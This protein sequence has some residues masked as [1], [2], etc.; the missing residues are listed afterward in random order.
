M[1]DHHSLADFW[2]EPIHTYTRADALADGVLV[3]VTETAREAGFRIPVALTANVWADVNDLSGRYVSTGQSLDGRLWDLLFMAAHAARRPENRDTSEF[4]YALIMPVGTGNNY[5]AKCHV[6][7]GDVGEPVLTIM[8]PDNPGTSVTNAIGQLAAD[9]L[10]THDL[11]RDPGLR[12][13][14]PVGGHRRARRD[15]RFGRLHPPRGQRDHA[16]R[17]LA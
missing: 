9:V 13:T 4:V 7:P 8:L 10:D 15:L 12:R 2:G 14:L 11:G 1:T 17:Y 5:R 3:D 16:W 6:G